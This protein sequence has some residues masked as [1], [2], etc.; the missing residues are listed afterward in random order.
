MEYIYAVRSC[1]ELQRYQTLSE[2][3][4]EPLANF[5][6]YIHSA[7]GVCD[8]PKA[9]VL[10]G[11]ETATKLLSN[12]PLPGYTNEH[13]TVF[14]PDPFVWKRIYLQQLDGAEEPMIRAY[15]ENDL[16]VNHILQILGHEFVHHSDLFIDDAWET[17]R[18]FE[19]GMCEY[20]SRKFFLTE[21]E[22]RQ[23]TAINRILVSRFEEHNGQQPLENFS[24]YTYEETLVTVFY[25]YWKS[26]LQSKLWLTRWTVIRLQC[27]GNITIGFR[28][29]LPRPSLTGFV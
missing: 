12:I 25:F 26:F 16:T 19:E 14:C 28:T 20:I 4:N 8:L 27:S 22:F 1:S 13:R 23:E 9:V 5:L 21:E 10:T 24:A 15:Y 11:E 2:H 7:Y 17:A 29:H 6:K 18:W 3:L